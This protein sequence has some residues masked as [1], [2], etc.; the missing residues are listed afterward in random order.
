M[1]QNQSVR[2]VVAA[3]LTAG[4]G[5]SMPSTNMTGVLSQTATGCATGEMVGIGCQRGATNAAV[6][7]GAALAYTTMVGYAADLRP[8]ENRNGT[9]ADGTSTG[10]ATYVPVPDKNSPTF[11]QQLPAD[12]GMNVTGL[13]RSDSILSQGGAISKV[14]NQ[15]PFFNAA[16]GWHDYIFNASPLLNEWFTVVNVPAM[17]PAAILAIPAS[18]NDPSVSWFFTNGLPHTLDT[19]PKPPVIPSIISLPNMVS[20]P[21]LSVNTQKGRP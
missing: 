6:T 4:V 21:V 19:S 13:N 5:A 20:Q 3:M 15:V 8:G 16:A 11:G 7:S 17:I 10:N 9:K 14:L 2:N 18:L 12:R 1:G